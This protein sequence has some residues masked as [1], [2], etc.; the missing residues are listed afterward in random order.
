MSNK[1]SGA[2]VA[3][4]LFMMFTGPLHAQFTVKDYRELSTDDT[5]KLLI[6]TY[7]RGLGEGMMMANLE[8]GKKNA[9]LY[10]APRNLVVNPDNYLN[11]LERQ[12][13]ELEVN[14]MPDERLNALALSIP[15]MMGLKKTFPC[16]ANEKQEKN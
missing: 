2:I 12:I 4:F 7:V 5:G 1:M 13:K 8:A 10:C 3:T 9:P 16:E 15:L 11:I 6:K 14:G